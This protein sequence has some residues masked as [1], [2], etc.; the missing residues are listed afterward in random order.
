MSSLVYNK[1]GKEVDKMSRVFCAN[2]NYIYDTP[3]QC[4][5]DLG[6]DLST[7][8]R[9]LNGKRTRAGVYIISYI[10]NHVTPEELEDRRKWM[11]YAAY[12]INL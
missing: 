9:A 3:V 7:V 5:N 6:L 1:I 10:D 2:N 11:L 12:K 4:A 8:S